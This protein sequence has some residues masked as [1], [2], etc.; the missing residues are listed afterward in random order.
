MA[1]HQPVQLQSYGRPPPPIDQFQLNP[2]QLQNA[3]YNTLQTANQSS[4]VASALQFP[5]TPTPHGAVI[6]SIHQK[7]MSPSPLT[8]R[9]EASRNAKIAI[10]EA[11]ENLAPATNSE[12]MNLDAEIAMV[13]G[14]IE[15]ITRLIAAMKGSETAHAQAAQEL[16]VKKKELSDEQMILEKGQQARNKSHLIYGDEY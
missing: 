12:H 9:L 13:E 16:F 4:Q 1:M 5:P 10:I 3:A 11:F 2:E 7:N 8:A 6:A 15:M 14:D